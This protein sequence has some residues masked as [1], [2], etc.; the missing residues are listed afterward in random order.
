MEIYAN[1]D[2]YSLPV[3]FVIVLENDYWPSITLL[4]SQCLFFL[5]SQP[6]YPFAF[7]FFRMKKHIYY[8]LSVEKCMWWMEGDDRRRTGENS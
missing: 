7:L 6:I 5:F 2:K 3:H 4:S 8:F 1:C